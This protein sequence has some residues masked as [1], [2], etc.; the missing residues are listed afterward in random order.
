MENSE[1]CFFFQI[2]YNDGLEKKHVSIVW[3]LAV[4]ADFIALFGD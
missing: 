4:K 2:M 1:N 3:S